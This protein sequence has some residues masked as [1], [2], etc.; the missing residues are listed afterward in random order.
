MRTS[1]ELTSHQPKAR[2]HERFPNDYRSDITQ[3]PFQRLL[4]GR[5]QDE[6]QFGIITIEAYIRRNVRKE[7]RSDVPGWRR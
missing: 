3:T 4:S 1:G 2:I 5:R 6:R 7:T